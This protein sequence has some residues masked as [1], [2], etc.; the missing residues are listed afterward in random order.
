MR[1]CEH[2]PAAT[3]IGLGIER[4]EAEADWWDERAAAVM[5]AEEAAEKAR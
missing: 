4:D 1:R 2:S 5:M 3:R